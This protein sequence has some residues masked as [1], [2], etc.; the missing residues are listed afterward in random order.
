[1]NSA[2]QYKRFAMP[3]MYIGPI[4][5]FMVCDLGVRWRPSWIASSG[6]QIG[7]CACVFY[8]FEKSIP[9][10][11]SLKILHFYPKM[12]WYSYSLSSISAWR[13]LT[14]SATQI[15]AICAK[16]SGSVSW[17]HSDM[18]SRGSE[19]SKTALISNTCFFKGS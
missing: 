10:D 7:P 17:H 15:N 2:L 16:G 4:L 12:Q 13:M 6:H 19:D 8:F 18:D 3:Y 5:K 1:M 14:R 9:K 11:Q